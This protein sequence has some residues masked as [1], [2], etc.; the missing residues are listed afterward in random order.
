MIDSSAAVNAVQ[1]AGQ[2]AA[3]IATATNNEQVVSLITQVT[4]VVLTIL[5]FIFG[6]KHGKSSK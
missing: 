2:V 1:I 4:T 6:H 5:A 3:G